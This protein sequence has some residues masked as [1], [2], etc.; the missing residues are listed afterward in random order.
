MVPIIMLFALEY[1]VK[2]INLAVAVYMH[3]K[4][5]IDFIQMKL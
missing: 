3:P 1:A 5:L 2:Y 4:G